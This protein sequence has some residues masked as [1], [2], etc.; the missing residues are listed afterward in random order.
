MA[1]KN[2]DR[3]L[4][5]DSIYSRLPEELQEM[6]RLFN[7]REKDIVLLSSLGVLSNC[8]PNING[9]YD[10]DVVYPH[11]YVMIVAP[12]ASGKGV[13]NYS[14]ELIAPIH[15][16][17]FKESKENFL[18][19]E[20]KKKGK[21]AICPDIMV[22]ELPANI[23]T[24]EM[25]TYMGNSNHGLL[26]IESE[27]DTMS[28]MLKNDWSNYS[29]VLRKAFHH[30]PISISRKMDK[31]FVSISEP[32]LAM[33]ISGTPD[34]L[35]PLIKSRENGLFSRFIIYSFDEMS[36]FKNVFD[37]NK[38]NYKSVFEKYG[39]IIFQLY[40]RLVVS[41]VQIEITLTEEQEKRFLESFIPIRND[42]VLNHSEGFVS[43]LN[44]HGLIM[45]RII[46]IL[47]VLRNRTLLLDKI[48]KSL[49]CL[50]VDF[51]VSLELTQT[52]LRHSLY[53]YNTINSGGMSIQDA[54]LL[55]DLG[56]QFTT[57]ESYEIGQ[58]YNVSKRVM[59]DKLQQ[60]MR[61]RIIQRIKRGSYKVL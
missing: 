8:F 38:A 35:Q 2:N 13:M 45:F 49:V 52:L 19:C 39:N 37:K 9:I 26:I 12:P 61:K 47:T 18:E 57:N 10:G 56:D 11:L 24:S 58:K 23:S 14:R 53:T 20:S 50:D 44:R 54:N 32:K 17:I 4:I 43:N 15:E 22:K 3:R 41:D 1:N 36:D 55:D 30:E 6:T 33:V 42:V 21:S 46:M 27:A 40:G 48:P 51:M 5:N 25:Y 16:K 59:D 31:V 60:W 7:D 29:D 28:N 34:Q